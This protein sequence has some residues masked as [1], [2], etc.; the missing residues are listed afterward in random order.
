MVLAVWAAAVGGAALWVVRSSDD[1]SATVNVADGASI[2]D[3]AISVPITQSGTSNVTKSRCFAWGRMRVAAIA[4][5]LQP[6]PTTSGK[7]A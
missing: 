1:T 5:T 7:K 6:N 3:L 2:N 4:G